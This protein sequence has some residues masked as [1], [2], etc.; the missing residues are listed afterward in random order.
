MDA[1]PADPQPLPYLDSPD[2]REHG[3]FDVQ[4]EVLLLRPRH[5]R[6]GLAAAAPV[7]IQFP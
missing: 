3:G 5:A 2:L 6:R 1:T 7:A 4:L